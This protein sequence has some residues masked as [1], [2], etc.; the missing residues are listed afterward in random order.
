MRRVTVALTVIALGVLASYMA[1]VASAI[2]SYDPA[3][4][5]E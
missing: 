2:R 1:L 5:N 3:T 4:F